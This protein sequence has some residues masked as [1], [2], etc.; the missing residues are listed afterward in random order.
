MKRA[1]PSSSEGGSSRKKARKGCKAKVTLQE[2]SQSGLG[3][4]KSKEKEEVV[5]PLFGIGVVE[6][7]PFQEE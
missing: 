5:S 1:Q 7:L 6:V 4:E 2:A 3:P